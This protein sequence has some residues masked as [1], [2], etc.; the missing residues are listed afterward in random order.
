MRT[1]CMESLEYDR[2]RGLL[3]MQEKE[4]DKQLQVKFQFINQI[5]IYIINVVIYL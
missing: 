1:S 5:Y 2:D 3:Y 4:E